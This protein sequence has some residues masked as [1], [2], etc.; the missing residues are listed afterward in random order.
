MHHL[1]PIDSHRGRE[2]WSCACGHS[3]AITWPMRGQP[4]T[5]SAL[6]VGGRPCP[7]DNELGGED[8]Q[9]QTDDVR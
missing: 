5:V 7:A 4:F 6:C 1:I 9:A 2:V 3:V 8:A